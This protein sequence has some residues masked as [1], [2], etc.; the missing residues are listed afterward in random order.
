[1]SRRLCLLLCGVHNE[2]PVLDFCH[3]ESSDLSCGHEQK[4]VS[5]I[6]I[7][8]FTVQ[9]GNQHVQWQEAQAANHILGQEAWTHQSQKASGGPASR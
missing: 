8:K 9:Q 4:Q 7:P 2:R 1:M 3:P 6:H 5:M